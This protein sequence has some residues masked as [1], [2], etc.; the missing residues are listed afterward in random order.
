MIFPG[1]EG[2]FL[3]E[4]DYAGRQTRARFYDP[5]GVLINTIKFVY[6]GDYIVRD[7]WY[8]ADTKEIEDEITHTRNHKGK[9]IKS[10][11]KIG[12]YYTTYTYTPDGENAKQW[13]YFVGGVAALQGDY[14]FFNPYKNP[15]LASRGLANSFPFING[16]FAEN[17]LYSTSEKIPFF[18]ENGN[19]VVDSDQDPSK[20][21]AT[22]NARNF[23]ATSDFYNILSDDWVHFVFDYENCGSC[24]S[25]GSKSIAAPSTGGRIAKQINPS[26]IIAERFRRVDQRKD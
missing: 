1:Y 2:Y 7:T 12:D 21:I 20:T 6:R 25:C 11:S 13:K 15:D 14:T 17:K 4:H 22:A 16:A 10:E 18:D 9:I 3:L 8:V 23:V 5:T 26:K 19:L 24:K